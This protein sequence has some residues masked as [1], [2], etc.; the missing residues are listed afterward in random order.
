VVGKFAR[1]RLAVLASAAIAPR[2]RRGLTEITAASANALEK[3]TEQR[4]S[5]DSKT[6]LRHMESQLWQTVDHTCGEKLQPEIAGSFFAFVRRGEKHTERADGAT[7]KVR[8]G[9]G[10]KA[11]PLDEAEKMSTAFPVRL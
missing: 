8:R 10:M 6:V 9:Q 3:L 5:Q 7:E 2:R 1:F 11:V 4:S